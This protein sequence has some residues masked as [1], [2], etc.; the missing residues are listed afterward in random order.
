MFKDIFQNK[1]IYSV[2]VLVFVCGFLAALLSFLLIAYTNLGSELIQFLAVSIA[3]SVSI[4]VDESIFGMRT[5]V[6]R[7]AYSMF[8]GI[9]SGLGVYI[10][11]SVFN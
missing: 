5:L 8:I 11:N 6:N 3:V 7:L 4:F 1:S 9:G 10:F 2:L